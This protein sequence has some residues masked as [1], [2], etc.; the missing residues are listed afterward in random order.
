M[1]LAGI[2][3]RLGA[4]ALDWVLI[5]LIGLV[6]LAVAGGILQ[7]AVAAH[8]GVPPARQA[9]SPAVVAGSLVAILSLVATPFVY[10]ALGWRRGGTP[11]MHA[12]GLRVIDARSGTR[13]SWPQVLLRSAGW[14]WSLASCGL[15]FLLPAMADSRRRG[16]ADRMASSLVVRVRHLPLAWVPGPFGWVLGPARPAAPAPLDPAARPVEWPPP[17]RSS[18]TWSD[19]VPVL[20]TML[21]II[22]GVNWVAVVTAQGLGITA[23]SGG[24]VALSY[25][26]E[27]A[28]YGGSLLLI[29][30][31]VGWRRRTSLLAV[32]LRLPS[33]P[34]LAAGIPLGFAAFVL[35]DLGG[36]ISRAIF[37][38]ANTTNQCVSIRSAFGGSL[39]LTLLAVAVVAPIAEEIIFRGFT[40]RWL[41]GRT[42]LWA[43]AV[44]S[45][46]LFSAAHVG[47]G[48]PSL[49]LPIFLSGLLLAYVYAKSQSVWPG[50]MVHATINA[51]GVAI[52]LSAT[53]C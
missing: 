44:V 7:A 21:P 26:D 40:L 41:Q 47:W 37:P 34:W 10:P 28:A 3:R 16:L 14:W 24:A 38:S 15:A 22:F 25:A 52:A 17:P 42:P 50:V 31:L 32:G 48:E 53:A 18:W 11:G 49:F 35:Q 46:V 43:A 6:G 4:A 19:V 30:L 36:L 27:I 2:G 9:G 39:A 1:E 13:L 12:F 8:P 51:L 20:V 5:A 33:W 45:A 23:G 29:G